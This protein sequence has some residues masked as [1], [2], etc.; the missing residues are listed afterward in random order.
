MAYGE[1]SL[2]TSP[3]GSAFIVLLTALSAGMRTGYILS[4]T[5]TTGETSL[6]PTEL[7]AGTGILKPI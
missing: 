5:V 7:Q 2:L 6:G 4:L 1:R 3:E